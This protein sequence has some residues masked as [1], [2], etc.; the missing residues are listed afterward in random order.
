M[1]IKEI[2]TTYW[3]QFTLLFLALGYLIKYILDLISKKREINFSIYQNRKLD[4]INKFFLNYAKVENMW[5]DLALYPILRGEINAYQIDKIIFG[6]INELKSSILE[7]KLFLTIEESKNFE[8]LY[9][10][11]MNI[12]QKL[13]KLYEKT[14]FTGVKPIQVSDEVYEFSTFRDEILKNNEIVLN[15]IYTLFKKSYK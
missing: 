1:T 5:F 6:S 10:R 12:S 9:E 14:T 3:S 15:E 7:I 4:S 8:L 2:F 13:K 11:M